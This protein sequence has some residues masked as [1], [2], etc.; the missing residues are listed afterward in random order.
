MIMRG[1]TNAQVRARVAGIAVTVLRIVLCFTL[2]FGTTLWVQSRFAAD[3]LAAQDSGSSANGASNSAS[4]GDRDAKDDPVN[5]GQQ[6]PQ[7]PQ[8][9]QDP[10]DPPDPPDPQTAR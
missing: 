3:A 2:A 8:E 4:S 9:P 6:D 1:M 10:Q 5:S 7:D